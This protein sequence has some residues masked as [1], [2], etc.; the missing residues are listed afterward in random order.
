MTDDILFL[1]ELPVAHTYDVLGL[2]AAGIAFVNGY[3]PDERV[4]KSGGPLRK[5]Q[6]A[7]RA[8]GLTFRTDWSEVISQT[9]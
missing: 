5:L 1:P 4:V 9:E 6:A 3:F 8:E 2:T 7:L